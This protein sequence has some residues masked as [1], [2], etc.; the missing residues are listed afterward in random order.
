M[1]NFLKWLILV[2]VYG[3]KYK[4]DL[5]PPGTEYNFSWGQK[6]SIDSFW[7]PCWQFLGVKFT[8]KLS[9]SRK[10]RSLFVISF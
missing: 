4:E 8:R 7:A 10:F 9:F 1:L 3:C 2:Q 5:K 6:L